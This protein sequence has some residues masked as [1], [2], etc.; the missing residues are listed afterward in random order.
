MD[1]LSNGEPLLWC[2]ELV[3]DEALSPFVNSFFKHE[4]VH[5][6]AI[7][8]YAFNFLK[9]IYSKNEYKWKQNLVSIQPSIKLISN[10]V[11]LAP[12]SY[13]DI[14]LTDIL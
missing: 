14:H 13:N 11:S 2:I 3:A 7:L 4:I 9:Y 1:S 8:P 10:Q 6:V 12:L 5:I